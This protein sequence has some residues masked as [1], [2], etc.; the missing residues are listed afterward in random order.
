[1]AQDTPELSDRQRAAIDELIAAFE[2]ER[3]RQFLPFGFPRKLMQSEMTPDA[4]D[5]EV[6]AA[7]KTL[8]RWWWE[9]LKESPEYPPKGK[10]RRTGPIAELYRDFGQLGDSF[11]DWWKRQ[12]R[13]VFAEPEGTGVRLLHDTAIDGDRAE[14]TAEMLIVEVYMHV[15]REQIEE[16]FRTLLREHHPGAKL[17]K[18]LLR[19]GKRTLY[20]R[21]GDQKALPNTLAVW[22]SAK[23]LAKPTEKNFYSIGRDLALKAGDRNQLSKRVRDYFNKAKQLVHHAARGDFPRDK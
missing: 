18:D 1:M 4:S 14:D 2:P 11:R 22:R 21:R 23:G 9:F 3:D 19:R 15:P 5:E 20:P 12:G 13:R 17:A 7:E 16:D 6:T 8:Y 10:S